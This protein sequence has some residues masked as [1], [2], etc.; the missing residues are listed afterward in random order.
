VESN[1]NTL[2]QKRFFPDGIK[3]YRGFTVDKLKDLLIQN[4]SNGYIKSRIL[5]ELG[6]RKELNTVF[7]ELMSLDNQKLNSLFNLSVAQIAGF[8]DINKMIIL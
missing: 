4:K 2:G 3:D 6:W 5:I 7:D 8:I 1:I